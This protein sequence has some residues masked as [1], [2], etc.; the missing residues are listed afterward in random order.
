MFDTESQTIDKCLQPFIS[1]LN[2]NG[3][4]TQFSCCGHLAASPY[5]IFPHGENIV[6]LLQ[7][8]KEDYLDWISTIENMGEDSFKVTFEA[9]IC[10]P[11]QYPY[12]II[13]EEEKCSKH[14]LRKEINLET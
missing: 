12:W 7:F 9:L 2:K 6:K 13:T 14:Q 3:I 8:L 10:T 5:I 11:P 4:E 1:L